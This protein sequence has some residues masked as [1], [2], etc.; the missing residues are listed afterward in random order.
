MPTVSPP[1]RIRAEIDIPSDKSISHRSLIFN[2]VSDGEARIDGLLDSED[3]RSTA[4]CLRALGV[5]IAWAEESSTANVHGRGL[6]GLF[7]ADDVL[8]CGNSG[9]TMRLLTGVP[10]LRERPP[11]RKRKPEGLR[12]AIH[13]EPEVLPVLPRQPPDELLRAKVADDLPHS[14]AP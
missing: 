7:E 4:S 13:T 14:I 8:D 10:Q 2:A 9:T 1:V 3:V 6:H 5:D 12:H 11:L